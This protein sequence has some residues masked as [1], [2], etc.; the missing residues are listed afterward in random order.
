MTGYFG[1]L[2]YSN[3]EN[4]YLNIIKLIMK[5]IRKITAYCVG[6]KLHRTQKSAERDAGKRRK[7]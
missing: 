4:L 3:N 5:H 1:D 2:L 7:R 6:N